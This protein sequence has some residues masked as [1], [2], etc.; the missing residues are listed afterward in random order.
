MS[1]NQNIGIYLDRLDCLKSEIKDLIAKISLIG[2]DLQKILFQIGNS[3]GLICSTLSG[4]PSTPERNYQRELELKKVGTY[5][6]CENENSNANFSIPQ[7][8]LRRKDYT[9]KT[10]EHDGR[11]RK[12][13]AKSRIR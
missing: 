12:S 1:R 11:V 8:K 13:V 6:Q 9:N 4:F 3:N 10:R 5:T 7:K 2:T